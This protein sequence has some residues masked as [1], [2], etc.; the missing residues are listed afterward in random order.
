MI[1][2]QNYKNCQIRYFYIHIY[3]STLFL[4]L[5]PVD[6]RGMVLNRYGNLFKRGG[7]KGRKKEKG[8]KKEEKCGKIGRQKGR[9][10]RKGR[11]IE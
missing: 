1:I 5:K 7:K 6:G 10:G 11:K 8:G 2:D 9:K 4:N 3:K